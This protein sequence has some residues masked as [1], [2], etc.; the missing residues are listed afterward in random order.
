MNCS[1]KSLRI[2]LKKFC[3]NVNENFQPKKKDP[4]LENLSQERRWTFHSYVFVDSFK[5]LSKNSCCDFSWNFYDIFSTIS[6]TFSGIPLTVN[7]IQGLVLKLELALKVSVRIH[8]RKPSKINTRFFLRIFQT[9]ICSKDF[10]RFFF[11]DSSRSS[12]KDINF[13]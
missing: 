4:L 5:D 1:G 13:L 7:F 6:W 3:R 9:L 10:S 8:P 12:S 11:N 2:S